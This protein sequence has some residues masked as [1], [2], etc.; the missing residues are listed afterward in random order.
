MILS[1]VPEM[2]TSSVFAVLRQFLISGKILDFQLP[3]YILLLFIV[4]IWI[5]HFFQVK[6]T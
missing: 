1:G 3:I 6:M 5:F 4:P 2:I